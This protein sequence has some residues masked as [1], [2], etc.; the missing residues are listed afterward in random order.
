MKIA[1]HACMSLLIY[2]A[3]SNVESKAELVFKETFDSFPITNDH[4]WDN[5]SAGIIVENKELNL[6]YSV[7]MQDIPGRI[8]CQLPFVV[9]DPEE[10]EIELNF[11]GDGA[12][13]SNSLFLC[14]AIGPGDGLPLPAMSN[15]PYPNTR[16]GYVV[17]FIRHGDGTN[18][19]KFYRNDTGTLIEIKNEWLTFNQI[20]TLR[21]IVVK[22]RREGRHIVTCNYDTGMWIT[23]AFSFNDSSYPPNNIQRGLYLLAKGHGSTDG[24]AVIKTDTWIVNDVINRSV[25][26]PKSKKSEI[27]E[28]TIRSREKQ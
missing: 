8:A 24:M 11:G 23:R 26:L 10:R 9:P 6:K 1:L 19:V 28:N 12:G 25:I 15:D 20:S 13:M 18:E 27:R 5:D 4:I 14:Y 22:H 16:T 3:W 17:R 2:M 7:R 21:R